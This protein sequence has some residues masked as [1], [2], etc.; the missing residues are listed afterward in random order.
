[1]MPT[2]IMVTEW[3]MMMT[4]NEDGGARVVGEVTGRGNTNY[5]RVRRIQVKI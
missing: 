3:T 2:T 5:F 1:M 4:T